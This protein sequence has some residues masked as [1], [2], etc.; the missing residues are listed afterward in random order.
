[1]NC[2]ISLRCQLKW[3]FYIPLGN[4]KSG[5][6]S[7]RVFHPAGQKKTSFEQNIRTSE[8]VPA[9]QKKLLVS[10]IIPPANFLTHITNRQILGLLPLLKKLFPMLMDLR[11]SSTVHT[12]RL[13]VSFTPRSRTRHLDLG[14]WMHKRALPRL[15][16]CFS[17]P[18]CWISLSKKKINKISVNFCSSDQVSDCLKTTVV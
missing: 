14:P 13:H 12:I 2:K 18:L 4:Y 15:H 16:V 6:F 7:T 1:M 10:F 3:S 8:H 17:W 11:D 5:E 9:F